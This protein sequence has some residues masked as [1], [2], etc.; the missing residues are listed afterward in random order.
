MYI[1]QEYYTS[2]KYRYDSYLNVALQVMILFA[3][4]VVSKSKLFIV[5][6]NTFLNSMAKIP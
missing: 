5:K 6:G 3:S 1:I 2:V 4:V